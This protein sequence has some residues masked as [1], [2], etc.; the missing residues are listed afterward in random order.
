MTTFL[1]LGLEEHQPFLC[2]YHSNT[3]SIY[4]EFKDNIVI[5]GHLVL[6]T[7][8]P[9]ALIVIEPLQNIINILY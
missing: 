7:S 2:F 5:N 1:P 9:L 4:Q 3:T 6:S 8:A